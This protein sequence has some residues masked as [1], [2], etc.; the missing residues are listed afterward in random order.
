MALIIL[1]I[2]TGTLTWVLGESNV[3]GFEGLPVVDEVSFDISVEEERNNEGKRTIHVPQL[4]TINIKRKVDMATASLTKYILSVKVS[5]YP[6]SL[7][8]FRSLGGGLPLVSDVAG[9]MQV[10]YLTM[11]LH[12]SVVLSQQ[13][14]FDEGQPTETLQVS[15]AAVEWTYAQFDSMQLPVGLFSYKF[16]VQAGVVG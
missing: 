12:K 5:P 14:T 7:F 8:F 4:S 3:L 10:P 2:P 13:V 16:D 9:M 6:W 1:R 11:T 15:P